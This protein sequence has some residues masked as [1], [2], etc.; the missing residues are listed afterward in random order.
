MQKYE[1]MQLS[2]GILFDSQPIYVLFVV[3]NE[4]FNQIKAF[5]QK[6]LHSILQFCRFSV[7]MTLENRNRQKVYL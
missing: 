4:F 5:Y 2:K 1:K 3:K 6:I 7:I